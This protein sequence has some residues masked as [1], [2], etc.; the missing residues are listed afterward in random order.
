MLSD[1]SSNQQVC[2]LHYQWGSHKD[3]FYYKIYNWREIISDK[4]YFKTRDFLKITFVYKI[5]M[6]E[7]FLY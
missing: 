2:E 6:A 3:V 4:I 1:F 7:F 5:L